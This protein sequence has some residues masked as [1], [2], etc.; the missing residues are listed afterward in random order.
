MNIKQASEI[1]GLS[2]DTIR[3]YERIEIIPPI[4]R[5]ANG[6]RDIDE[7][8]LRWL[9][10]SRQMRDAGVSIEALIEYIKLFQMGDQSIPA[11]I[12]LL[13]E[14]KEQLQAKINTLSQ[15]KDRLSYKIDNYET[16][17]IQAEDKLRPFPGKND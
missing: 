15:A 10:F 16:H 6:I 8:D 4:K 17:T 2:A 12:K 9:Q 14:Q 11:R 1:S 13:N 3:Y 7:E 5:H